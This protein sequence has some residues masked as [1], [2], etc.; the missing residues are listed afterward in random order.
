MELIWQIL[1]H[2]IPGFF[3][4]AYKGFLLCW[5][6]VLALGIFWIIVELIIKYRAT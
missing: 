5:P 1:I 3:Q 2:L 4:F 6:L